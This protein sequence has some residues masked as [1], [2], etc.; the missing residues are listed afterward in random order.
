MKLS[1]LLYLEHRVYRD[2]IDDEA[3]DAFTPEFQKKVRRVIMDIY[4]LGRFDKEHEVA[5]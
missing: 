1:D 5:K 3:R 2:I 4:E